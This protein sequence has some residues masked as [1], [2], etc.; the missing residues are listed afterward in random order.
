[1]RLQPQIFAVAMLPL[2]IAAGLLQAG[3]AVFAKLAFSPTSGAA[4]IAQSTC[5]DVLATS[6]LRGSVCNV[7]RAQP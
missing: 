3:S 7:V 4:A 6:P 2:S 1:V 5:E